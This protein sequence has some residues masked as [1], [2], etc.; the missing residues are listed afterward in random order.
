MNVQDITFH[1]FMCDGLHKHTLN[2]PKSLKRTIN[3]K[4]WWPQGMTCCLK[5]FKNIFN[6]TSGDHLQ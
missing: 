2:H 4:Q 1:K 3:I 5:I 6:L